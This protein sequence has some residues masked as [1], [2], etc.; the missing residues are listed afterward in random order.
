MKRTEEK[1]SEN[2]GISLHLARDQKQTATAMFS[3]SC[4]KRI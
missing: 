4:I 1:K 2:E 3:S